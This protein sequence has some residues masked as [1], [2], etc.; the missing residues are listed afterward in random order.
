MT[1]PKRGSTK[2][3]PG[4]KTQDPRCET[5]QAPEAARS[6]RIFF[7]TLR[8]RLRVPVNAVIEYSAMLMEDAKEQGRENFVPD[9]AKIHTLGRKLSALVDAGLDEASISAERSGKERE[10]FGVNLRHELRTPLNAIIGYS[11]ML[12]EDA[13]ADGPESFIPDLREDPPCGAAF[14]LMHRGDRRIHCCEKR[15][16]ACIDDTRD[17]SHG[18]GRHERSSFA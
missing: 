5:D 1:S 12:M 15:R 8:E 7:T 10:D 9:L 3:N 14:S 6:E 18:P 4:N 11:E 13:A 16:R 17:R 2:K